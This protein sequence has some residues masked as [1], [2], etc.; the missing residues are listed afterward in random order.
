MNDRH[1]RNDAV[2]IYNFVRRFLSAKFWFTDAGLISSD[3]GM[4]RRNEDQGFAMSLTNPTI[5]ISM[6]QCRDSKFKDTPLLQGSTVQYS[7]A[8]QY[9]RQYRWLRHSIGSPLAWLRQSIGSPLDIRDTGQ[10]YSV[11]DIRTA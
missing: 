5:A 2:P 11:P 9:S 10:Y 6:S 4:M 1:S 3:K 7:I 8:V